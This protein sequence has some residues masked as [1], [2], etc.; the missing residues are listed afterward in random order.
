MRVS[1]SSLSPQ[2]VTNRA[3]VAGLLSDALGCHVVHV[4]QELGE[5]APPARCVGRSERMARFVNHSYGA[6]NPAV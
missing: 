2:L 3:G 1:P 5:A 6:T 4:A